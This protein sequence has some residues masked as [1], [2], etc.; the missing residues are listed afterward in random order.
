LGKGNNFLIEGVI[1]MNLENDCKSFTP[2]SLA[3]AHIFALGMVCSAFAGIPTEGVVVEGVSVPA[4]ALGF[5]RDQ[6]EAVYGEPS[7]CQSI[8]SGDFAFC[9]YNVPDGQVSV[10]YEGPDGGDATASGDDVLYVVYWTGLS[11]WE[12]TAG[13]NTALALDDPNAVIAAYPDATVTYNNLGIYSVRDAQLGIEVIWVRI[14]YPLP[15]IHVQMLIFAPQ[16]EPP[17]DPPEPSLRSTSIA[18]KVRRGQVNATVTV[19]TDTGLLL[20]GTRIFATW[21]LP[22]GSTAAVN[23]LTDYNGEAT[24][25]VKKSPGVFVFTIDDI[26][27]T[28][29]VFDADNSALSAQIEVA[30]KRRK[31]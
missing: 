24:F 21:T 23:S 6:V 9:T 5:T 11:G 31:K 16:E 3:F 26:T 18:M 4:V 15:S 8:T 19:E 10:R 1:N 14:I 17:V 30:K 2:L 12:T 22:D 29:Y 13:I 20:S 28:G 25:E 7:Y 27:R